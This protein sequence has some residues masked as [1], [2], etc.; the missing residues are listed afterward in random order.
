MSTGPRYYYGLPFSQGEPAQ[1]ELAFIKGG[2]YLNV[3]VKGVT[4]QF[5]KGLAHHV[6]AFQRLAWPWKY[7][8]RWNRD[9]ILPELCKRGRLA[10]FGPSSTGKSIEAVFF[11][12]TMFYARPKGTTVIFSSTTLS[13]LDRRIW[14]YALEFD[15]KARKLHPWLPGHPLE[16]KRM[17]LA[18]GKHEEGRS[19]KDGVIGVACKRGNSWQGLEEYIGTKNDVFIL[20]VDESQFLPQSFWDAA[21]NLESNENSYIV[22]LGNLNDTTTPLGKA[23]EPKLG[24][25]SLPDSDISRVYETRWFDGR[26]VQL[27]GKDSPNLDYPEGKE[28]FKKLIGR[29]YIRQQGVNFG[30]DTPLYDMFVSGKIPRG[31][32]VKRI[33][34]RAMVNKHNAMEEA[35]WGSEKVTRIYGLDAAY[36]SIGG[37][38]TA[39]IP[40]VFGKDV[41]GLS[42]LAMVER[43]KIYAG[44]PDAG[45]SHEDWIVIQCKQ[46][47]ERL[48]VPPENVFY[49]GT[50]RS[51]LTSSFARLWS[52]KVNPVEFGGR[53]S[54]RPN[55]QGYRFMEGPEKGELKPCNLVF[56]KFVTELWFAA[57]AAVQAGQMRGLTEEVVDEGCMRV[58]M[59]MPGGKVDVEKKEETRERMGR[60][61]DLFDALVVGVEGARR[62]GFLLGK[63]KLDEMKK[64]RD[65]LLEK[66]G[67]TFRKEMEEREL[68][69]TN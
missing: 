44:S 42:R 54:I 29:R 14:G 55:F 58:W 11:G 15:Q 39:G 68:N 51:S 40:M 16:S 64:R 23:A 3:K 56:G 49:D 62:L 37:D 2:G 4:R 8:H 31:T 20:I 69:Y 48:G 61:P 65:G 34:T 17:L 45:V 32:M 12:L 6:E 50:G 41:E 9:L 67:R 7:W 59:E 22:A 36:S 28:P 24:W 52:A 26:A 38:R 18:D 43:P 13:A 1:I 57:S 30:I 5:G 47:C 21:G 63:L 53:A 33:L 27:I 66:T 46:E 60:S 10:I 19:F 25:D 35:V